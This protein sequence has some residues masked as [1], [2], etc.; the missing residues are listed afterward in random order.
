MWKKLNKNSGIYIVCKK[1]NIPSSQI[2]AIAVL[3]PRSILQL[4]VFFCKLKDKYALIIC[5]IIC[6]N[7]SFGLLFLVKSPLHASSWLPSGTHCS[8]LPFFSLD[9]T[10]QCCV[11]WQSI[12]PF[13]PSCSLDCLY[14]LWWAW[15]CSRHWASLTSVNLSNWYSKVDQSAGSLA[16]NC[17]EEKID[18]CFAIKH[19]NYRFCHPK[20]IYIHNLLSFMYYF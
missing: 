19:C 4:Q 2:P 5:L 3:R 7:V 10:G 14:K 16:M 9:N 8:L 17:W 18:P 6:N 15:M 20:G 13:T 1:S 11:P 12:F